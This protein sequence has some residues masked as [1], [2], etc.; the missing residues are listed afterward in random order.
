MAFVI[1]FFSSCRM[2][3]RQ[4]RA[5]ENGRRSWIGKVLPRAI[6]IFGSWIFG[7]PSRSN[8]SPWRETR[9]QVE[10]TDPAESMYV[11]FWHSWL[12]S[13]YMIEIRYQHRRCIRCRRLSS[14]T[15]IDRLGNQ[16]SSI[17]MRNFVTEPLYSEGRGAAAEV[18]SWLSSGNTRLPSIGGIKT[19]VGDI[20]ESESSWLH[21]SND[22]A[23]RYLYH[24]LPMSADW[25]RTG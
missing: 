8:Q 22:C 3:E 20:A 12:V 16:V 24:L 11:S 9:R 10:Y 5:M 7:S 23:Y 4:R 21:V 6:S 17:S 25:R 18:D 14:W 19:R 13:T 1:I 15:V 2:D